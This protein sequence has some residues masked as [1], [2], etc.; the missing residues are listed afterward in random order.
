[1]FPVLDP[2]FA[3]GLFHTIATPIRQRVILALL[4]VCAVGALAGCGT[5]GPLYLPAASAFVASISTG[6]A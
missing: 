1:M 2:M 3:K 6:F 4:A 5:K